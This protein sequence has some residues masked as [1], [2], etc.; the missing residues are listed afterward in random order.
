MTLPAALIFGTLAGSVAVALLTG[1]A[2]RQRLAGEQRTAFEADLALQ[3]AIARSRLAHARV[4]SELPPDSNRSLIPPY[5]YPW[6]VSVRATATASG[7]LVVLSVEVRQESTG[8]P[9]PV[10]RVGGLLLSLGPADTAYVIE[11]QPGF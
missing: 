8:Q 10:V 2:A 9:I 7:A 11:S 3:T 5:V 1:V 4:L 6:L